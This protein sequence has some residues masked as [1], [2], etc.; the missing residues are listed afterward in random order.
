MLLLVFNT[1]V[2]KTAFIQ[3]NHEFSLL[4]DSCTSTTALAHIEPFA[5]YY[6]TF[7][8][9]RYGMGSSV[10]VSLILLRARGLAIQSRYSRD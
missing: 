8:N 9:R 2:T 6:G 1:T 5:F 3:R 7:S 4:H 10:F